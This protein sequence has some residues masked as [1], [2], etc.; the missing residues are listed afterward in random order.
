LPSSVG[1]NR[2][3]MVS[4]NG[5]RVHD[6]RALTVPVPPPSLPQTLERVAEQIVF[7]ERLELSTS[8]V[9]DADTNALVFRFQSGD[10]DA[11]EQIYMRYFDRIYRYVRTVIKNVH[12]AE[13][14]TQQVFAAAFQK[15][16]YYEIRRDRP[17]RAWL[18]G[19]A[20]NEVRYHWRQRDRA[21]PGDSIEIEDSG[22]AVT[23]S[24]LE[25]LGWLSDRELVFLVER[26]PPAQCEV[27]TMRFL[28]DMTTN[29][30]ARGL[31]RTPE[32]VRQ[33]QSRALRF[34]ATRMSA[35]GRAPSHAR[36]SPIRVILRQAPVLRSRR[37]ALAGPGCPTHPA[38]SFGQRDRRFVTHRA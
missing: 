3:Q 38:L 18:F 2:R 17:F 7:L 28:L 12:D 35:L 16:P 4:M 9:E 26:L 14:V 22:E 23:D 13:D 30:I 31:D 21:A 5:R 1:E 34:L 20:R 32:S 8:L 25:V 27:L 15:L 6:R 11:F 29:E 19:F 10:R 33:L 37:F 36:R 24:T